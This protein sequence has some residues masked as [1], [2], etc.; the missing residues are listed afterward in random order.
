MT[1]KN[2]YSLIFIKIIAIIYSTIIYSYAS[3]LIVF[4]SDKYLFKHFNDE[5]DE[6]INDKSTLM[7]FT[8]FTI[9]IS[10]IGILAYFGRNILCK[11]PFPLDNYYEFDYMRLKEVTSGGMILYILFSFSVILNKK[12]NI[13]RK[14]LEMAI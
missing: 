12:I 13:L 2:Y 9:I 7:H 4:Y 10:I 5:T 8:E 6:K 1:E 11:V 3:L 14:R